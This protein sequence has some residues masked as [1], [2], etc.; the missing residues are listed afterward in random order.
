MNNSD[1]EMVLEQLHPYIQFQF[2]PADNLFVAEILTN[3]LASKYGLV[4]DGYQK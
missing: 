2:R 4:Q 1:V 3:H